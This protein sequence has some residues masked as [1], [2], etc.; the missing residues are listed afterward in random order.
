[1]STRDEGPTGGAGE[2]PGQ[3]QTPPE[4]NAEDLAALIAEAERLDDMVERLRAER[5]PLD[6][7]GAAP[8]VAGLLPTA[9]L[10]RS[11]AA[12]V[13]EPRPEFVEGL[14]A[15][16]AGGEGGRRSRQTG[17]PHPGVSRRGFLR[18]GAVAA[19]AAAAGLAAGAA[20]ERQ[21]GNVGTT[22]S[23]GGWQTP[24]VTT[25][26]WVSVALADAI[27]VGGVKRFATESLVG[28]L[29]RTSAGYSALSAACTHMGC[30]VAWN[31]GARSFDCPC[32]GGRFRED[33]TSHP[34]STVAYQ[35][36]PQIQTKVENGQV[37]VKAP[38]GSQ[39][40]PT[41]TADPSDA[42]SGYGVG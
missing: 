38:P 15:R 4:R 21:V 8:E 25:G 37:W 20:I 29:R 9:A 30:L 7:G 33:G 1:M 34:A 11:A 3:E 32:H 35:P 19:A 16:L 5:A 40:A 14:R 27:P 31:A 17:T 10:L 2:L 36:L 12:D 42:T 13:A 22:T 18:R 41:G 26:Q 28:Y 24:L 6:G 23:G 39:A